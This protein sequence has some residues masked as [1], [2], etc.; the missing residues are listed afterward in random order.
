MCLHVFSLEISGKHLWCQGSLSLYIFC[1]VSKILMWKTYSSHNY[2][3]DRASLVGTNPAPHGASSLKIITFVML[4]DQVLL[5]FDCQSLDHWFIIVLNFTSSE[6]QSHFQKSIRLKFIAYELYFINQL[7]SDG[8]GSNWIL[9]QMK[10]C[11]K[12]LNMSK[13]MFSSK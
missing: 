9:S 3:F 6:Y 12:V 10:F 8:K 11:Q 4:P 13:T 2:H 1:F 5:Q 7:I